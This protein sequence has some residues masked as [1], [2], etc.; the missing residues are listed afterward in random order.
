MENPVA[1]FGSQGKGSPLYV[2]Q[3]YSFG[4]YAG[5]FDENAAGSTNVIKISVYDRAS[6]NGN[7]NIAPLNAFNIT[8][9]RRTVGADSNA[10]TAFMAN[11]GTTTVETNGL[12][13][14]VQFMDTGDP[15]NK[16]FG[17]TVMTNANGSFL[18]NF[19]LTPYKLTHTATSTNYFYKVEVLGEVQVATNALAPMGTNSAGAWTGLPLYTLD[20]EQQPYLRSVYVDKLYFQGTPMPPTYAGKSPPELN[21][22]SMAVTNALTLTNN[23]AYTNLDA[24]PELRRHPLLDQLVADMKKDPLA[25]ASYVINEIDLTDPYAVAES[26]QVVKASIN[27]GGVNRIALSTFLEGQGSPIEQC[28][29]LVYLL[30]QAGYSAAYVFPT[31]GNLSMLDTRISQLWRVQVKGVVNVKGVP[32]LTNSLI[33]VNYPWVA[34]NIGTNTVHIF[35]WLKDTEIV[36]G[37]DLYDYMPTNYNTALKW[38]EDYVRGKTNILNLDSENLPAKLF[39]K[40]VQQMLSTNSQGAVLSLDDVG[41]RAFNRRHQYP[42]W[43]YL[44]QPNFVTN[45]GSA[46]IVG[47]LTD[48]TNTFPFLANIF[49]T[50][51]V[52]IYNSSV[53]STN[54]LMTTGDW[55]ACDWHDR[56]FLIFTNN[57]RLNLWLAP[58]TTNVTSVQAFAGPSSTATQTNSVVLGAGTNLIVQ[59]IHQRR[60]ARLSQPAAMFPT[61]E[62]KSVTH[63]SSCVSGDVAAIC[64][65]FGRVTTAMLQ[66]YADAYWALQ[67]Q[68]A[69]NNTFVPAVQ[70]YQGTAAYLLGMGYFQKLDAFDA[71]NQQFHKVQGLVNF[72]SGL[73]TIGA[74]ASATNICRQK[75]T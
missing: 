23:S 74:A 59:A 61:I 21:G 69:T 47:S 55:Y 14:I 41:V 43:G 32:Y 4:V 16:P 27:C 19:I 49:D 29:L 18:T 5:G 68:R 65:D 72:Q 64:L 2:N 58:Y 73:G 53:A 39:P 50:A 45:T 60:V 52:E 40:F 3:P 12:R 46:A 22:L 75:W 51:R 1:A 20:F 7:T 24:S 15:S 35:P 10:W 57:A 71:Q 30:R 54:L 48:S 26:N 33:T 63:R 37:V 67:R 28:A 66:P 6:F 62:T 70:D 42:D 44:P 36:E 38:C 13:T 34:A 9:P 17:L 25:L 31:N 8:L 11:G 56:K